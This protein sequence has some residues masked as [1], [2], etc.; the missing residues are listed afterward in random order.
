MAMLTTSVATIPSILFSSSGP[1]STTE[2]VIEQELEWHV[3]ALENC[4][5]IVSN[6]QAEYDIVTSC[7]DSVSKKTKVNLY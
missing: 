4:P 2:K 3:A 6:D 1:I 7:V 5:S